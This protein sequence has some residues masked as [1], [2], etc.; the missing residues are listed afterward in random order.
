MLS[1]N[2]INFEHG[3]LQ[4]P[5][6]AFNLDSTTAAYQGLI[7]GAGEGVPSNGTTG[8]APGALYIDNQN[9]N[10][11]RNSGNSTSSTWA[12]AGSGSTSVID[13]GAVFSGNITLLGHAQTGAATV[14]LTIP[15]FNNVDDTFAFVTLAQTLVNK[16][17]TSP[18]I[19]GATLNVASSGSGNLGITSDSSLTGTRQLTIA[20]DS[21]AAIKVTTPAGLTTS[22]L[23]GIAAASAAQGE[24]L[25]Y[26]G[27]A[28]ASL[29]VGTAGQSL[30]S[31]GAAANP[32]WGTISI[33]VASSIANGATLEDAG[34]NDAVLAFTT[35]TVGAPT[36]TIPDFASVSDTF[37][38]NTLQATLSNKILADDSVYFG[39][40]GG[41]TKKLEFELSGATNA[42][43]MTIASSHSND[44]TLTLPDATDTLVG[45][46]T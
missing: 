32:S 39:D 36:L 11:Y 20:L 24:V 3:S 42:K 18:T 27:T 37:T 41:L 1:A 30:L 43:T 34:A 2:K 6:K 13:D 10:Q 46:A 25:Y 45:K 8:W 26:N 21:D 5:F 14:D 19:N 7:L 17:L 16:T 38:F 33:G 15:D 23:V 22:E 40:S 31:N 9:G 12:T 4:T 28:W 44:R 35:Q 29:A